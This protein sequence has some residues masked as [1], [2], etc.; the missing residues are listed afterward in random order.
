MKK[1]IFVTLLVFMLL[2][3]FTACAQ[4]SPAESSAPETTTESSSAEPEAVAVEAISAEPESSENEE[5]ALADGIYS[6]RFD[7]DSGMFHVNE[8][9]EGR[10][11]LT[12]EDG[13]MTVHITL[14][15]KSILNLF[16]GTAEDAQKE[17]AEILEA[18][19]D[20][21]TYKDGFTETVNGF[22]VPVEKLNSEFSLAII[23]KKGVWYDHTVSVSD[24]QPIQ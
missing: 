17:G 23:G 5:A 15:S 22:D 8:A 21:V 4:S 6:V 24:P 1:R 11:T 7:T 3:V 16:V 10:G 13:K 9:C 18:T 19:L 2:S 14:V 20:E 12:V